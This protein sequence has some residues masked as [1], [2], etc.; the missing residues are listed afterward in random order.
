MSNLFIHVTYSRRN[1]TYTCI[2]VQ[3]RMP[4]VSPAFLTYEKHMHN[5]RLTYDELYI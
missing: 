5:E 2:I 1:I 4:S 3:K